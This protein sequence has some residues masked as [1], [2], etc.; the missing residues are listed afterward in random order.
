MLTHRPTYLPSASWWAPNYPPGWYADLFFRK[1][2]LIKFLA[3]LEC[4]G[5]AEEEVLVRDYFDGGETVYFKVYDAAGMQQD[6]MS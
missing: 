6:M 4:Q 5:Y 1:Q 2:S 3:E